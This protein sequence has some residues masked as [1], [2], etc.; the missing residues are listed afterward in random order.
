MERFPALGQP[1]T[2]LLDPAAAQAVIERMAKLNVRRRI[3]H[4]L[5]RKGERI[6]DATL[7]KFD[8]EI[9]A[10]A[11]NDARAFENDE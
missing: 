11:A 10:E 8:R 4:P 7:A 2:L 5:D 6:I 1:W 3:C 9:D